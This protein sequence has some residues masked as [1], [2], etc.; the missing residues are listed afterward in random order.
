MLLKTARAGLAHLQEKSS[1]M[2]HLGLPSAKSCLL[3]PVPGQ[4]K[5]CEQGCAPPVRTNGSLPE[6]W[7]FLPAREPRTK[8]FTACLHR[9]VGWNKQAQISGSHVAVQA[10]RCICSPDA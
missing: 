10:D 2:L 3:S 9:C 7:E 4:P 8:S 6:S 1:S 5:R